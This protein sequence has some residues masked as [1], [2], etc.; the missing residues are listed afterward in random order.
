MNGLVETTREAGT[1]RAMGRE[2]AESHDG[3]G[4][5][6]ERGNVGNATYRRTECTNVRGVFIKS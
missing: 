4:N 5:S 2:V 3:H 6:S 1:D